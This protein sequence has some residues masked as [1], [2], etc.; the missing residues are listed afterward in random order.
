MYY[1]Y[2][3]KQNKNKKKKK[4]KDKAYRILLSTDLI[5]SLNNQFTEEDEKSQRL[6][7]FKKEYKL[8]KDKLPKFNSESDSK[9]LAI[10]SLQNFELID[11]RESDED[12]KILA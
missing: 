5:K 2:S 12:G 10:S 1:F 7:T 9:S 8:V 6:L 4:K 3:Q 11:E